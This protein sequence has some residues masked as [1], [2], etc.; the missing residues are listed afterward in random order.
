MSVSLTLKPLISNFLIY[1]NMSKTNQVR[2]IGNVGQ[3]PKLVGN[4]SESTVLTFSVATHETY[5]DAQG[6]KQKR[7]EW[8][9]IVAFGRVASLIQQ[10]VRQ[11]QQ[12]MIE[13]RLQT[14]AYLDKSQVQRYTTEIICEEVL[15][16]NSSRVDQ[17]PTTI[18]N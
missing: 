13:G 10:Y 18:A 12:L 11:G 8:H 4:S 9:N 2:L 15:F 17:E 5:K 14:R 7:T 3:D 1:N 6:V 16:L